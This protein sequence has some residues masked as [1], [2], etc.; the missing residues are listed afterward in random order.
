M[1]QDHN[2][3]QIPEENKL[4]L[5]RQASSEENNQVV[6]IKAM[7]WDR[8]SHGLYDYESKRVSKFEKRLV[9]EGEIVRT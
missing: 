2:Q 8:E 5:G 4:N 7:T 9:N 3:D 1:D 6:L